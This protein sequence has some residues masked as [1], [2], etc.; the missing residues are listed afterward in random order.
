ME[1]IFDLVST[2]LL[3]AGCLYLYLIIVDAFISEDPLSPLQLIAF[4]YAGFMTLPFLF[5]A[6]WDYFYWFV[7]FLIGRIPAFFF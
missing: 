2:F 1:V 3:P 5:R 7:L 4:V 6:K